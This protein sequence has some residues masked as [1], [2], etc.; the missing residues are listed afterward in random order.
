MNVEKNAIKFTLNLRDLASTSYDT[1]FNKFKNVVKLHRLP[2]NLISIFC[3]FAYIYYNF[4][5][6]KNA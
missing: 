1:I 6:K 4:S 2:K 3:Y 5:S